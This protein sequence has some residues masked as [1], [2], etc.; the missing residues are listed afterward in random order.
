M[1]SVLDTNDPS[2][3]MPRST[4]G[5]HS[6]SAIVAS[7]MG[8]SHARRR[9]VVSTRESKTRVVQ[10]NLAVEEWDLN[11]ESGTELDIRE[12]NGYANFTARSKAPRKLRK[13][14][15]R[16]RLFMIMNDIM[17]QASACIMS[18]MY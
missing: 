9:T 2:L 12:Q 1:N 8:H 7:G 16:Q 13:E 3:T 15:L 5:L 17:Q 10:D 4:S 18:E 6:T 11:G 14:V